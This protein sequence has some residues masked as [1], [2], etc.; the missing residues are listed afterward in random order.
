MSDDGQVSEVQDMRPEGAAQDETPG[1]NDGIPS[2]DAAGQAAQ[3]APR[4]YGEG[5]MGD[6]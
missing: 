5:V 3:G 1:T 2:A 6:E 4:E